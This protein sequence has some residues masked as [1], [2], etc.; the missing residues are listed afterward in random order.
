[1]IKRL[2]VRGRLLLTDAA[3]YYKSSS[4]VLTRIPQ[5]NFR[6]DLHHVDSVS[7][8]TSREWR[9]ALPTVPSFELKTRDEEY[10]FQV[11]DG[12]SWVSTILAQRQV[13]RE[14]LD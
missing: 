10:V 3:L 8:R 4:S 7:I 2:R 9:A 14:S 1:L 5:V 6:L 12:E 11:G 13:L